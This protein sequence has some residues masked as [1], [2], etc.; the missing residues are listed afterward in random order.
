MI[1]SVRR[2]GPETPDLAKVPI[3]V[4]AEAVSVAALL[5]STLETMSAE[6]TY[7]RTEH[8]TSADRLLAIHT[9]M[10]VDDLVRLIGAGDTVGAATRIRLIVADVIA[11]GARIETLGNQ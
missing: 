6:L 8:S 7:A 2:A 1:R 4:T 10:Y 3:A 11:H 9:H 5:P